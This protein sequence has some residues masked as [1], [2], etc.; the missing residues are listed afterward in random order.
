MI[1]GQIKYIKNNN[2]NIFNLP[3]LLIDEYKKDFEKLYKKYYLSKNDNKNKEELNE[4]ELNQLYKILEIIDLKDLYI[5]SRPVL[6]EIFTERKKEEKKYNNTT[7]I[8]YIL[9]TKFKED[10]LITKEE[11]E[12]INEIL[13]NEIN[14]AMKLIINDDLE[15]K[16]QID[17]ILNE[18]SFKFTKYFPKQQITEGFEFQ[19]K[20]FFFSTKKGEHFNEF[21][22]TLDKINVY[23]FNIIHNN[24][25]S[26]PITYKFLEQGGRAGQTKFIIKNNKPD[27]DSILKKNQKKQKN[28]FN[29]S[30]NNSNNNNI[31]SSDSDSI[32]YKNMKLLILFILILMKVKKKKFLLKDIIIEN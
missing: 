20:K 1:I 28:S 27:N 12:K 29:N 16:L 8:G 3:K 2:K 13:T 9:G 25:V 32:F 30:I 26:I 23:L 10:E 19:Y 7:Y 17:F 11:H 14:K 31:N 21:N 24:I 22:S 4:K 5:W 15:T 6:Q 18:R